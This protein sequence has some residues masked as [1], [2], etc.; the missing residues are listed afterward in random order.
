VAQHLRRRR[1]AGLPRAPHRLAAQPDPEDGDAA[2]RGVGLAADSAQDAAGAGGRVDV[3]RVALGAAEA[4]EQRVGPG[5][6]LRQ[7]REGAF[8]AP[9]LRRMEAPRLPGL[10][11]DHVVAELD[12]DLAAL[13]AA[14]VA[15]AGEPVAQPAAPPRPGR[16][17]ALAVSHRVA[18]LVLGFGAD[19]GAARRAG[20]ALTRRGALFLIVQSCGPGPW[21]MMQS[22][23]R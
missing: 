17:V 20:A 5:R 8:E 3:V 6:L 13:A 21:R 10:L 15:E 18:Q 14:Q 2:G 23:P 19:V 11:E 4:Q 9:P 7:R 12:A 22:L 16:Q 1:D